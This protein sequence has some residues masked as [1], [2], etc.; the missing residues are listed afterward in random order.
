[1]HDLDGA[2]FDRNAD[3]ML[4]AVAGDGKSG[5]EEDDRRGGDRDSSARPGVHRRTS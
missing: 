3:L 1:M 4:S 5:P 2:V